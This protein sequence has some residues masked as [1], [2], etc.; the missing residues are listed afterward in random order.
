VERAGWNVAAL[1]FER[2]LGMGNICAGLA[3]MLALKMLA[4]G[5][6]E[7]LLGNRGD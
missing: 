4:T 6:V 2:F 7:M 3:F 5:M 1:G